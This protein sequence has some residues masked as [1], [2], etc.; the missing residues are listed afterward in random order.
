MRGSDQNLGQVAIVGAIAAAL[1]CL[2]ILRCASILYP[3]RVAGLLAQFVA[4]GLSSHLRAS[5]N[6]IVIG[7]ILS[8]ITLVLPFGFVPYAFYEGDCMRFFRENARNQ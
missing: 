8:S 2:V 1:D 3:Q 6:V 7:F 5:V 4:N